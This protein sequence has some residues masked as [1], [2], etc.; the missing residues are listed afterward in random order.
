MNALTLSPRHGPLTMNSRELA[1]LVEQRHD[2]VKRT[3]ERLANQGVIEFPQIE[4][5]PTATKPALVYVFSGEKGKRDS[6]IVVAQLSPQFTAR[7]V[8]RWQE[9]EAALQ[10]AIPKTY[11]EALRLAADQAEQLA[12]M[13]PKVAALDRIAESTGSMTIREAAKDLQIQPSVL[14]KW[15]LDNRWIFRQGKTRLAFQPRINAGLMEHKVTVIDVNSPDGTTQEKTVS[16]PR[17]TPKGLAKLAQVVPGAKKKG[18][19]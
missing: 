6:I 18:E 2:N 19:R 3:I 17:I 1:E 11:A 15:L 13:A 5:I 14:T 8:D 12:L 7:L 9:L 16:Q 10:N 4:E